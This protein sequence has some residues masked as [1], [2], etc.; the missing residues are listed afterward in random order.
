MP[1]RRIVEGDRHPADIK[2]GLEKAGWSLRRLSI[3]HGFKPESLAK[4]LYQPWP[5]AE[6]LIANAIGERPEDLWPSR[7]DWYGES[8][9]R[10][11]K[12]PD[13]G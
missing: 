6:A 8:Y 2:A 5:R 3:H 9:R 10:L 1:D 4:A 7:Y 13:V 12:R 11:N